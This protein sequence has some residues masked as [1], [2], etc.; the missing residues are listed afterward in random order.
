MGKRE[1]LSEWVSVRALVGARTLY[2]FVKV[3]VQNLRI[4]L[5]LP[6]FPFPTMRTFRVFSK[7]SSSMAAGGSGQARGFRDRRGEG[8]N[9]PR[10][11][12]RA[13]PCVRARSL[14]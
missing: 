7:S 1:C 6:T 3:P 2:V 13:L 10:G 5:L 14:Q 4:M 8:V 11:S 12:G 9:S